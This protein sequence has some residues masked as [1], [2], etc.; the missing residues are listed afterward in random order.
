MVEAVS[1]QKA[2]TAASNDKRCLLG[3]W[4]H[5]KCGVM[6]QATHKKSLLLTDS[7]EK[8]ESGALLPKR[9]VNGYAAYTRRSTNWL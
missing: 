5:F 9:P 4:V 7:L 8:L 6:F 2:W 1:V 3:R